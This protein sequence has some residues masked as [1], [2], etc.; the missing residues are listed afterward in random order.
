M[1]PLSFIIVL[2]FA[3]VAAKSRTGLRY[4][5]FTLITPFTSESQRLKEGLRQN[6]VYKN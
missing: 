3:P 6:S 5:D 1:M 4:V 2:I